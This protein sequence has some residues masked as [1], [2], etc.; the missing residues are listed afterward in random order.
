M[1]LTVH[2]RRKVAES[3]KS[4][5]Y[6]W[7]T[8][9]PPSSEHAGFESWRTSVWGSASARGLGLRILASLAKGD[10]YVSGQRLAELDAEVKQLQ[11]SLRSFVDELLAQGVHIVANA[12][13]YETIQLRLSNIAE[14]VRLA[15]AIPDGAGEVVIW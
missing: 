6:E 4:A 10:L 9:T 7:E 8:P 13:P 15:R 2:A 1:S 12:D 3:G 11:A 14:A 5:T